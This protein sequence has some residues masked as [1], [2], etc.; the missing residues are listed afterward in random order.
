[1]RGRVADLTPADTTAVLVALPGREV[2]EIELALEREA[3][4]GVRGGAIP[5]GLRG[6]VVREGVVPLAGLEREVPP[7]AEAR[8][9]AVER[10]VVGVFAILEELVFV[11]VGLDSDV[12]EAKDMASL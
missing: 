1:V 8:L 4:A 7:R 3:L 2:R 12:A 5:E 9:A 10:K 11:L 6:V